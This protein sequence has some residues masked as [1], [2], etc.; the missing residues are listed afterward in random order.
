MNGLVLLQGAP[1]ERGEMMGRAQSEMLK[2]S[3]EIYKARC[4]EY[5]LAQTEL[6]DRA[7]QLTALV[8]SLVPEWVIEARA[9]AAS[10]GVPVATYLG[11][12]TTPDVM[13]A[14][15]GSEKGEGSTAF[16][17]VG[18]TCSNARGILHLN[19]DGNRMPQYALSRAA[20]PGTL[21]YVALSGGSE[22]GIHAFVNESGLAGCWLPGP[23]VKDAGSGLRPPMMLRAV[24][25]RSVTCQQALAYFAELQGRYGLYTG[26]DRGV[27]FLF[28]DS[29]GDMAQV[30]ARALKFVH[31][32]QKEGMAVVANQ[33]QLPDS[34]GGPQA[35]DVAR[36]RRLR[37]YALGAPLDAMR[38]IAC[39]RLSDGSGEI[40]FCNERTVAAFTAVL[41]SKGCP[42]WAAISLGS[43][44][45][46]HP[47][48]VFPGVG[49]TMPVLD[50]SAWHA[51]ENLFRR[52]G[53]AGVPAERRTAIDGKLGLTL[54]NLSF[55]DVGEMARA[56]IVEK[57]YLQLIDFMDE[58]MTP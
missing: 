37:E 55:A 52:F 20:S 49:V 45:C 30:E 33:F 29:S 51:A 46:V 43:P 24:A 2:V 47:I 10:A 28:A 50:G 9:V 44:G 35:R 41:G 54:A 5:G 18:Q 38:A 3:A 31:L 1:A 13:H 26:G 16:A 32:S 27:N 17:A 14:V 7:R 8:N 39:A 6:P 21:A 40:G 42:S 19:R 58:A 36:Q 48:A 15:L 57:S 34:P 25:E 12:S 53:V 22:L 23:V 4:K 11:A 56:E